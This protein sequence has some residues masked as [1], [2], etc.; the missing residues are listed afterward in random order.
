MQKCFTLV[1]NMFLLV[2]L[3]SVSVWPLVNSNACCVLWQYEV[4]TP[5]CFSS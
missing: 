3:R 1:A 2:V 5:V 4:T